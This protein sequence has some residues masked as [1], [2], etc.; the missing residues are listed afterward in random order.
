M[1]EKKYTECFNAGVSDAKDHPFA[2]R[3][4]RYWKNYQDGFLKSYKNAGNREDTC[5]SAEDIHSML[6]ET[7]SIERVESWTV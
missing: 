7:R 6:S 4:D 5:Q 3:L 2:S 1:T